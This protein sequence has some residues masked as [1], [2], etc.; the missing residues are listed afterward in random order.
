MKNDKDKYFKQF[1][2]I[3]CIIIFSIITLGI[4]YNLKKN[5][6]NI[7]ENEAENAQNDFK[8]SILEEEA[9][10]ITINIMKKLNK[11]VGK[12][13]DIQL[14]E[15]PQPSDSEWILRTDNN[16]KIR[17]NSK[18]GNLISF[19]DA[20][21]LDIHSNTSLNEQTAIEVAEEI[22]DT[23]N[24]EKKHEFFNINKGDTEGLWEAEF[25]I[26]YD[27][28]LNPYQCIRILFIGETKELVRLEIFDYNYANN[29]YEISKDE[30]INIVKN[31]IDEEMFMNID[32]KK[33]IKMPNSFIHDLENLTSSESYV[34]ENIV[35]NI[36]NVEITEKE[37][38]Y[39]IFYFVDAT[40]G[41]IIGGDGTK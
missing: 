6:Q 35:R 7:C 4:A 39:K 31:L 27:E 37:N 5:A 14:F 25:Y 8:E 2:I 15:L 40:T 28:M 26:K 17:L 9:E 3:A 24:L 12:I 23:L 21:L 30:A 13:I 19:T 36:W 34:V 1:A 33:D 38:G 20:N 22:Y 41:K 32:A 10:I 18:T 29:S 11:K 16:F